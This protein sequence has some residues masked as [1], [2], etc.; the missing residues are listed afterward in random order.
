MS[1]SAGLLR[2][3]GRL[4]NRS[5]RPAMMI[6]TASMALAALQSSRFCRAQLPAAAAVE[7]SRPRKR[8][9]GH[10]VSCIPEPAHS[11]EDSDSAS[12]RGTSAK[13]GRRKSQPSQV[14]PT[15]AL[16][17]A[18]HAQGCRRVAGKALSQTRSCCSPAAV[19]DAQPRQGCALSVCRG[20][21]ATVFAA[22]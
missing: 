3:S 1:T 18:L 21:I 14:G 13:P 7:A 5:A 8:K 9:I 15:R 12:V 20:T 2:R 6:H 11:E 19:H 4:G 22:V 17:E 10:D 16:E